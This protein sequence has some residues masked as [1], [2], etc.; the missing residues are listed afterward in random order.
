MRSR[1]ALAA[2]CALAVIPAHAGVLYKSVDA[3][4]TVM[5]SDTPPSSD[6]ARI[7]DQRVMDSSYGSTSANAPG[8]PGAGLEQ[9]YGLIDS[10]A[11]L[12]QANARV[13]IAEHALALARN[14]A[15][16]RT[17]GLRLTAPATPWPTTGASISTS[18]TSSSPGASWS[19]CCAA[20]SWRRA[21]DTAAR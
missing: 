11:A 18:A 10:D 14:G 17:E 15:A 8:S 16:P 5:F 1:L 21:R 19:N 2:A 6:G 9:V 13:D 12:A 20:A 3:N 7:V 4:G